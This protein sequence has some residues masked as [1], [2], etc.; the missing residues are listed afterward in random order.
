VKPEKLRRQSEL[1][2]QDEIKYERMMK[3]NIRI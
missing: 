1:I 2:V 3:T